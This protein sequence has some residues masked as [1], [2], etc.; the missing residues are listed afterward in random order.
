[1]AALVD[2]AATKMVSIQQRAQAKD[3]LDVVALAE[4][5]V[6]LSAALRAAGAV[7]SLRLTFRL[8]VA[9]SV[10]AIFAG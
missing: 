1:V 2:I 4:A 5:G 7:V 6:S 8:V 10:I 9:K 3:Y